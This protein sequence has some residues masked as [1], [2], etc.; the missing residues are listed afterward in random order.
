MKLVR[1]ALHRWRVATAEIRAEQAQRGVR[2][3][4]LSLCFAAV[5]RREVRTAWAAW[6]TLIAHQR[7]KEHEFAGREARVKRFITSLV[8][9]G[10]K[11]DITR[12]RRALITWRIVAGEMAIDKARKEAAMKADLALAMKT[13][14]VRI[15]KRAIIFSKTQDGTAHVRN[16]NANHS[17]QKE[18]GGGLTLHFKSHMHIK[19]LSGISC[20]IIK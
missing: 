8:R 4:V 10:A 2:R 19:C 17:S 13:E 20:G 16:V 12:V 18:R 15:R 11:G 5:R 14:K 3:A 9:L 1:L 7:E 6:T